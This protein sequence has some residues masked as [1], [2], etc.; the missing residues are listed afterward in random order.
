MKTGLV[1]E[2]GAM[3]GMYTAGILDVM[4]EHE[5]PI[6]GAIGVSAG[7]LFGVNY[8]SGQNGRVIR[9][10]KWF[11]HDPHYMGILPL[12]KEGNIIST[13]YAYHDVPC[14]LDVFDDAAYQKAAEHIPFYAVVTEMESGRPKYV[15]IRSVYQ[16]MDVLRASASMPFVS[17]P[18][19]LG[20]HCYLDGGISDSIPFR[21]MQANGYDRLIVVLTRDLSYRKKPMSRRLIHTF[22]R[23]Y[24]NLEKQLA[25][26]HTVYNESV[27][28]LKELEADG[29]AFVIRPSS[30]IEIGRIESDPSKLQAVYELG[31]KDGAAMLPELMQYLNVCSQ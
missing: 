6:N 26:R 1:L 10:N 12:I 31:L 3:R 24:P 11:N 23:K 8:L 14:E 29:H 25:L 16:Q 19:Q 30:P 4:M 22:Y 28:A 27:E 20:E 21:W 17:K 5:I 15:R 13:E 18:V 7:A 9:Y 2:G